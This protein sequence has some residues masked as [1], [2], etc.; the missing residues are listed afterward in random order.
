VGHPVAVRVITLAAL[1][2][3]GCTREMSVPRADAPA[4]AATLAAQ[5]AEQ[6][7]PPGG[8]RLAGLQAMAASRKLIRTGQMTLVVDSF[9]VASEEVKRIA[10]ANGGYLADAQAQRGAQD[11]RHGSLTIRVDAGRF[12]AAVAALRGLGDV[13][14][15]NVGAQDVTKAYA[16]L[17]T[18]LRVKRETAERLRDILRTRTA[19]LSDVLEAER[20]LA[21]V[22]EE[23]EGMEGERRF[24]DQQVALSTLT[25]TLQEPAA[26]VEA[27]V[28]APVSEAVRDSLR[29]LA[30][31]LAALV[32]AAVFLAPWLLLAVLA[33]K[34]LR[35]A[36]A[37]RSAAISI[38]A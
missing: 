4:P 17:E 29:V 20:E 15:E 13:R 19:K 23:I 12:D 22:T 6:L 28:F 7:V 26:I 35:R 1:F 31:S 16:D 34:L 25:V 8:V 10:E 37:R 32:Y 30:S 14:S 18:R 33:W 38:K 21:R 2:A 5:Q 11:R 24:Y 9:T 3:A 36:R 27:N